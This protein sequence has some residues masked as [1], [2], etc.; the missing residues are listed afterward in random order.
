LNLATEHNLDRTALLMK[1]ADLESQV[2]K[3]DKWEGN[4]LKK[5]RIIK[6]LKKINIRLQEKI[7]KL[8]PK[9]EKK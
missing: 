2:R 9:P 8:A 1:I 5:D 3:T 6:N 4:I 7:L